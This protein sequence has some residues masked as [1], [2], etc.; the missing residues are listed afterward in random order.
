MFRNQYDQDVLTWSPQGRLHQVEYAMEA[1]KQ[2]GAAVGCKNNDY[3]VLA[4]LKRA[5][6]ELSSSQRK[7]FKIDDNVGIAISGLTADGTAATKALRGDCTTHK[8]TFESQVDVGRL[9]AR[10]ADKAQISTQR[11]GSRPSGV[12]MLIAGIDDQGCHLFQT[13]PSGNLYNHVAVAIGAR[14]QASKTYLEKNIIKLEAL[15]LDE[16][17]IV[18]LRALKEAAVDP[19][20]DKSCSVAVVGRGTPFKILQTEDLASILETLDLDSQ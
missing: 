2:G 20:S 14:S 19:I 9:A 8:F 15:S 5:A 16:L 17:V 12:G 13:C 4:T 10:V 3:A 1:V 6:S 7:L 11:S 18:A